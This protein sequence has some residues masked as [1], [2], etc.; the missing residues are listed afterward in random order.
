MSMKPNTAVITD[1]GTTCPASV[2]GLT[3]RGWMMRTSSRRACLMSKI[4]RTILM[5]PPVEPAQEA[6][7]PKNS[8]NTGANT[9][10]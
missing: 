4:M 9:G 6:K 1:I 10:H 8:R 2:T 3:T 5:P 7:Q